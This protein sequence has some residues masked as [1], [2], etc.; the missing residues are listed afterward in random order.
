MRSLYIPIVFVMG[1]LPFQAIQAT[2]FEECPSSAYLI[3]GSNATMYGVNLATGFY[4]ELSND[5]STTSKINAI[6]FN[7]HDRY[8]Y[9]YGNEW[10]SLIR[11]N[12]KFESVPVSTT[13]APNTSFFVGDV[14]LAENKY[15]VYR[16]GSSF[17]LFS[18]DLD[19]SSDNYLSYVQII[20]GSSLNLAIYDFAFHPT[21]NM[22]YSVTRTGVL[23]SIDPTTGNSSS[24]GNVGQTGTFGAVYFDSSE[25][26]YISRNSDGHVFRINVTESSPTAE[27]FAFGPSSGN[28]DGARCATASIIGDEGSVD[29]GNAPSTYGTDIEGNGARHEI[30]EN[31]YLGTSWGGEDDG[32]EFVTTI[33]PGLNSI[34]V[35]EVEGDGYLNA[36]ADWNQNGT[37]EDSEK[38]LENKATT[39]GDNFIQVE[40]PV[41]ALAGETWT[42]VRYS[43]Q[44]DIGA[45]GGVS[46]GEV[47]DFKIDVINAGTS[48]VHYP[49]SNGYVT[50]AYED[51]W[52]IVGDYDM[53]DVVV[54]MRS[55]QYSSPEKNVLRYEVQGKVLALGAG[56]NNG[57]AIQLDG[58]PTSAIDVDNSSLFINGSRQ[59]ST[60]LEA[61]GDNDDAVFVISSD[62]KS[63]LAAQLNCSY[64]R[65]EDG[66]DNFEENQELTFN[67]VISLSEAISVDSAPS[68][69]LNPFIFATPGT[70][71]GDSFSSQPGRSLEIHLKN[72]PV[73]SQF[74]N[75][76]M[77]LDDDRSNGTDI[78]FSTENGMPWAL[79]VPGVW[80]HPKEKQDILLAYPEF[81][82]FVESSAVK[83]RTWYSNANRNA[84]YII[85]N[86]LE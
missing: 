30:S 52:P 63:A 13:N 49:S 72:K 70:Y 17:G 14:S 75:E 80:S 36:W 23:T 31:L 66:C 15:F 67:L 82:T 73:S 18:V 21:N 46:D 58:I 71:H 77:G 22:L 86:I 25:Y 61:N 55:S 16:P 10:G 5:L 51:N 33:E 74:N 64:Y 8:I 39:T 6:G 50:L 28:N 57:F 59:L 56:Y 43:T 12:S 60:P 48:V 83:G 44:T 69:A 37:F 1:S 7:V 79:E 78:T 40:V 65:T 85:E 34:I 45:N 76:F 53:N 42:R 54:A 35:A 11:I 84:Q 27:F 2:P 38:F 32:I 19:P 68:N 24:L 47:E 20:D 9:G 3:Q 29:F 26:F 41:D 4:Q 62:L 81:K